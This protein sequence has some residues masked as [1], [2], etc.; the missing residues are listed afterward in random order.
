MTDL[1]DRLEQV[2]A[3]VEKLAQAPTVDSHQHRRVRLQLDLLRAEALLKLSGALEDDE[4]VEIDATSA[5]R[6]L[7]EEHDVD[8]RAVAMQRRLGKR[9]VQDFIE[10]MSDE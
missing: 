4:P 7:A 1:C 5:A 8:L 10:E 3:D 9:D 2:R 6:E